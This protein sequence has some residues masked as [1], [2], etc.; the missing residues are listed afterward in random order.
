MKKI[1]IFQP[2][3]FLVLLLLLVGCDKKK[4][5]TQAQALPIDVAYPIVEDVVLTKNY[6]GYLSASSVVQLVGRV[7]G[8]LESV[9]YKAGQSVRKGQL[10]FVI[11]PTT[12]KDAVE[13]AQATLKTAQANLDYARSNCDRM[14]VAIKSDAVSEIQLLQAEADVKE[15]EASVS[16]AEAALNTA[17]TTLSYCYVKAPADGLVSRCPYSVGT[18]ISG[19]A[20]PVTL[21]SLY[22]D[23][24]M[25]AYFDIAD[26][27]WLAHLLMNDSVQ[28]TIGNSHFVAVSFAPN[29][30]RQ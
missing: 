11:E 18:Y 17:N 14:R 12:Y 30:F 6:P 26:N 15:Y 21:A 23:Q 9:H 13:Q 22:E 2:L 5:A 28:N 25:Y 4:T 16:N 29:I 27:Q 8:I 3:S 10:L 20:S 7:N 1:I 19:A 24:N